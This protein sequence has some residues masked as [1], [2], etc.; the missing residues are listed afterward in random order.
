MSDILVR[1]GRGVVPAPDLP[2]TPDEQRRPAAALQPIERAVTEVGEA[3][4]E[5]RVLLGGERA[6]ERC[7]VRRGGR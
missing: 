1:H 3:L 2:V 6:S 5:E 7:A 4:L